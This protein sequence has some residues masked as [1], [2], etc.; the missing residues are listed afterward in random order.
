MKF[1]LE[2]R[3]IGYSD[4]EIAILWGS[5]LLRILDDVQQIAKELQSE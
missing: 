4:S 3:L 5:N 2:L 1:T